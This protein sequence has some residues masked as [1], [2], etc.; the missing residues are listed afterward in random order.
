[1]TD[2]YYW[3]DKK[4]NATKRTKQAVLET[5]KL[6]PDSY[7]DHYGDWPPKNYYNDL[8]YKKLNMQGWYY[9]ETCGST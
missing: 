8:E 9:Y 7:L 1:M 2:M 5:S 6:T 3:G 4:G